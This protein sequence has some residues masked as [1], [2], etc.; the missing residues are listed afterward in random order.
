M[1]ELESATTKVPTCQPTSG[2]FPRVK[3]RKTLDSALHAKMQMELPSEDLG[4]NLEDLHQQECQ[5]SAQEPTLLNSVL[6]ENLEDLHHT[7]NDHAE[8]ECKCSAELFEMSFV[9]KPFVLF[10]FCWRLGLI[11]ALD[12]NC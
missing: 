4:E 12:E 5:R 3:V 2:I 7:P 1:D 8:M 10:Y 6:G 11:C 9:D